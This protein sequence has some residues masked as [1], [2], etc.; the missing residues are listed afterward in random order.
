MP[1]RDKAFTKEFI[2]SNFGDA[3]AFE[4]GKDAK[5]PGDGYPDMG[6]GMFARKLGYGD[7]YRFNCAQR[8][9]YNSLERLSWGIP[10]L[11]TNGIFFPKISATMGAVIFVGRELYRYGYSSNEGPNSKFVERGA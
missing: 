7:W 9:H 11:I 4:F 3:H 5:L 6:A 10:L 8:V 1:V 2:Q